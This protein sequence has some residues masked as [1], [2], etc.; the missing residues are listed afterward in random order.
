VIRYSTVITITRSPSTVM[1]ALL[2]GPRY[3]QWTE[4]VDSRFDAPEP[5][6]G[7]RGRFRFAKGPLAGDYDMEVTA[8]EPD[9]RL[10]MLIT[11]KTLTWKSEV[12]LSPK[13]AGT[14]MTYA[15][16]VQLKGW[17][18]LLEPLIAGE[19]QKG[20]AKEAA[21]LKSLLESPQ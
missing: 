11:G 3:A 2:D 20:E 21:R 4:M 19:V 5:T 18:R 1:A 9:R 6:V 17:R 12:T 7:T 16:Q 15:G 14:E 8:L 10:D 13:G